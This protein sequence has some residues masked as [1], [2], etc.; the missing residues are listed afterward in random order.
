METQNFKGN[1]FCQSRFN[2]QGC[3]ILFL[4][5][6]IYTLVLMENVSSEVESLGVFKKDN[7]I[8]LKQTCGNCTYVNITSVLYPNSTQI[9]GQQ[10]MTRL[11][12]DYSYNFCNTSELGTY[13][14]LGKGDVDGSDTVFAYDFTVTRTGEELSI[15]SSAVYII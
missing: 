2:S 12:T 7:C 5:M 10:N 8:T 9:L 6:V 1:P 4:A 3:M 15:A 13:I 11:G 14:V